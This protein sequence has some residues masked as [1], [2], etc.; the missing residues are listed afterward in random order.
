M[1]STI[2][3]ALLLL[4][5]LWPLGSVLAQPFTIVMLP[6]TQN[7]V[8]F[9]RQKSAGFALDSRELYL[10]QM[11]HIASKGVRNGGDV[12][13]VAAVGDVWQHLFRLTD[14]EHERRGIR[15]IEPNP[16]FSVMFKPDETLSFE[17][18]TRGRGLPLAQRRR[19]SVRRA[20]RQSRL[21]RHV[22]RARRRRRRGRCRRRGAR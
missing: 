19:H 11:E 20:A 15:S 16:G 13:F 10:R 22:D 12:V 3:R 9:A 21:R 1:R 4:A 5:T 14:P 2:A 17:I 18:P 6:D 8:D 7:Y